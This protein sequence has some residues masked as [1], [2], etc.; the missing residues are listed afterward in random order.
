M[1]T[2]NHPCRTAA[3][4]PTRHSGDTDAQEKVLALFRS[5]LLAFGMP[6]TPEIE[7]AFVDRAVHSLG[8]QDLYFP[9]VSV[10]QRRQLHDWIKANWRGDNS[11]ELAHAT[12]LSQRRIRQLVATDA[13]K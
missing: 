5:T 11:K 8:G 9:K 3:G 13:R 4:A 1:E 2:L 7:K 12:G 10:Q 6:C